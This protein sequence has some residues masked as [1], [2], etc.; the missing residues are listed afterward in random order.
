ML[1]RKIIVIIARKWAVYGQKW[2]DQA[3]LAGHMAVLQILKSFVS[4]ASREQFKPNY[5]YTV[6]PISI[7]YKASGCL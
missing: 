7:V 4:Q 1:I 2:Y 3:Q 6:A 5:I